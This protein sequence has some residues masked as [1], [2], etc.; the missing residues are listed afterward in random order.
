MSLRLEFYSDRG[1]YNGTSRVKGYREHNED[2]IGCFK[3]DSDLVSEPIYVIAVCD[4]MGGGVRGKYASSLTLQAIKTAVGSIVGLENDETWLSTVQV[5]V[6]NGIRRAHL[7]LCNEYKDKKICA[8]TATVAIVQGSQYCYVQ[9]GDSRLYEVSEHQLNLV[10]QDDSWVAGQIRKGLMTDVEAKTHPKRHMITKAVGVAK[11]FSLQMSP[12][13]SLGSGVGLLLTSD[14][15]S[16]MLTAQKSSLIWLKE[17]QL[18]P[19]AKMMIGEGQKDNI[20]AIFYK[21]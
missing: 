10:T 11:G 5:A 18:E 6:S 19:M 15:F 2:T 7:Q 16:E 12:E 14:G 21:D 20:S 8:T 4:G 1:G 17:D 3:L 13:I 9:I